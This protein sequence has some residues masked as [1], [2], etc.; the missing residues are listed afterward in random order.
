M[1]HVVKKPSQGAETERE[2]RPEAHEDIGLQRGD[3]RFKFLEWK[4]KRTQA[5]EFNMSERDGEHV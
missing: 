4:I 5:Y 2:G 3:L 1:K